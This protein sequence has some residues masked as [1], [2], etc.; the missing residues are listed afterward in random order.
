MLFGFKVNAALP[1]TKISFIEF[2][3][4]TSFSVFSPNAFIAN[5]PLA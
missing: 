3:L 4:P 2:E 1:T 5:S